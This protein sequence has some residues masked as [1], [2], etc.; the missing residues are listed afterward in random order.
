MNWS[1]IGNQI[2][3]QLPVLGG[4]LGS[5]AG[6]AGT[7]TGSMI[8]GWVAKALGV[9]ADPDQVAQALNGD[10]EATAKLRKL[11]NDH[12][13]ELKQIQLEA[14]KANLQAQSEQTQAVN[15]TMRVE[16]QTEGLFKSGWRPAIGWTVCAGFF[17]LF[18]SLTWT[19]LTRPDQITQVMDSVY[20]LIVFGAGILGVN[21]H[22]RSKDKQ[23]AMTGQ[24]PLG[25]MDAI[26]TRVAGK[27]KT[28]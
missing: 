23:T 21:I 3:K 19:I 1:D 20:A 18:S 16:Y 4:A 8:G 10:P 27:E 6:P 9:D 7:A 15:E 22:Q 5:A 14:H 13:T 17:E 11:E 25:F 12:E 26:K 24:T 28:S 2:A